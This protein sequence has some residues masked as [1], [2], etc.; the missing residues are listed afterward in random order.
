M[1]IR[2]TSPGAASELTERQRRR[3]DHA[4][5]FV[6]FGRKLQLPQTAVIALNGPLLFPSDEAPDGRTWFGEDPDKEDALLAQ[7][8]AD[9]TAVIDRIVRHGYKHRQLHLCGFSDGGQVRVLCRLSLSSAP[10][11]SCGGHAVHACSPTLLGALH[12][13]HASV[14]RHRRSSSPNALEWRLTHPRPARLH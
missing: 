6:T 1:R 9:L 5:N 4:S 3:R 2:F 11:P 8:V 12:H 10:Q 14:R 7:C 13:L